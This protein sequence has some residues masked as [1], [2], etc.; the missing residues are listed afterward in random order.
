MGIRSL[1]YSGLAVR[2][3]LGNV[4][5]KSAVGFRA[6]LT[7]EGSRLVVFGGWSARA[8]GISEASQ[9]TKHRSRG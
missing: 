2:R 6:S 7:R 5:H 8:V 1:G 9:H 4:L 3:L